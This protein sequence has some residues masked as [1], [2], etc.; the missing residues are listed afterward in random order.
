MASETTL[1]R[2]NNKH[3]DGPNPRVLGK[4]PQ[5]GVKEKM[6]RWASGNCPH[7]HIMD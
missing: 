4:F 5:A 7:H 3:Q 6:D 2:F 1:N